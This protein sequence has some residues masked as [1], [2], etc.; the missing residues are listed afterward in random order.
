MA[1]GAGALKVRHDSVDDERDEQQFDDVPALDRGFVI[2]RKRRLAFATPFRRRREHDV[3]QNSFAQLL[4]T[5][6]E[7]AN[8]KL[9]QV[10]VWS[11]RTKSDMREKSFE[12]AAEKKNNQPS[13]IGA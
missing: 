6:F 12:T 1:V 7:I 13:F 11:E 4:S 10:G 3:A 8:I 9:F 5:A 2:R